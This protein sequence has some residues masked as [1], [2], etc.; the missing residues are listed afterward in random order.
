MRFEIHLKNTLD[1]RDLHRAPHRAPLWFVL[2]AALFSVAAPACAQNESKLDY[3]ITLAD[4]NHHRVHVTMT[5]DP[6]SGGNEVQ[7]PV[8]NA[9]YQVR[10]FAKN[11]IAL[12]ASSQSGERL[13][14]KQIDKTTWE[15]RPKAGWATLDYDVVLD[16]AGPFGA[17]FNSHHA[18]FNFAE[19]LMYPT[20]GRELPITVR[21]AQIPSGWKLATALDSLNLPPVQDGGSP[22]YL[23]RAGNYDRLVDS[24]CELGDFAEMDF[25][26]GGAKYRVVI[27]ADANDYD[28]SKL[29]NSLKQITAAETAWM[30]D[31]PFTTYVFIYHFP[32]GPAGGGMEHAFS[33]AIDHSANDL[34]DLKSLNSVS[35]HEFFHLWNVKR[36]RPQSLE[37]ID[38]TR[39]NYTRALWFSEGVTSTVADLA[40]LKAGLLQPSDY[41]Q[42]LSNGITVLQSRSAHI[43]Q[44]AE[45]SSLDTWLEKYP[46]YRAPER[47]ISYYNK[48]EILG[49]L[50]DL[51]IRQDSHGR[52]SLRDL[53]RAMNR[54]YAKEGKFFPD[55]DGVR[56]EAEKLTETDLSS[57]FAQYVAGTVELPYD[58]LFAGVGVVLGKEDRVAADAGFEAARN[59]AGP[60]VI[61]DVYGEQARSAGLQQGM[62]IQA[63]DGQAPSRSLDQQFANSAPGA[64][65]RL[66]V[67]NRGTRKDVQ[68]TLGER[69][70]KS[71]VLHESPEATAEQLARRHAWLTSEDEPPVRAR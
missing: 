16:E 8:W 52:S 23:L 50:L 39:E 20:N 46:S 70:V 27:D 22:G 48:G 33:T 31:R 45:E 17:Q 66:T 42:R 2:L 63:V 11:V 61:E 38:Y 60:L 65:V 25:E 36:I 40:L 19:V 1:I 53:F 9:L 7:L 58:E 41:L 44:S 12:K 24:P 67:S 47:S 69:N 26:Q 28:A 49:V 51:K 59:F 5:Y 3:T 37:P 15:F 10:D 4:A 55:S 21:L 29:V 62:E 54:D 68:L 30:D 64:K 14:I 18:F 34:K 13:P 71:Y 32:R 57:F 35:A 56:Q 43:T 6:E